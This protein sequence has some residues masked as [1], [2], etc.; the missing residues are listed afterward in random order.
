MVY[1][2]KIG[3][4][5]RFLGRNADFGGT[6]NTG[7]NSKITRT[8]GLYLLAINFRK[9]EMLFLETGMLK[10]SFLIPIK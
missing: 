3:H 10:A 5:Y 1:A 9:V 4:K 7:N 2:A 8:G 6:N